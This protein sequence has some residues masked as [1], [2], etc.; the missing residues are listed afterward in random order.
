MCLAAARLILLKAALLINIIII[1]V[2]LIKQSDTDLSDHLSIHCTLC[3]ASELTSDLVYSGILVV[4]QKT[5]KI[6]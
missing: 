4:R 3:M 6:S 1:V 5:A 2:L